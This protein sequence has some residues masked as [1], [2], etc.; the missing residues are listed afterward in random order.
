M[1]TINPNFFFI[2]VLRA[3]S[4]ERQGPRCVMPTVCCSVAV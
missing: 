2:A 4:V 1:L 3:L